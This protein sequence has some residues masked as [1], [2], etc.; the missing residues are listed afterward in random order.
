[1]NDIGYSGQYLDNKEFRIKVRTGADIHN[2]TG[3]A[4]CGEMLLVTGSN[5]GLYIATETSTK[6]SHS[7]YLV[8]SL[9][10][11]VQSLG[12]VIS[13]VESIV[14]S[15]S[16]QVRSPGF[17]IIGDSLWISETGGSSSYLVGK[18]MT[19]GQTIPQ[20]QSPVKLIDSGVLAVAEGNANVSVLMDDN[21]V[22]GIGHNSHGQFG[23]TWSGESILTKFISS[24]SAAKIFAG[25]NTFFYTDSSGKLFAMGWNN[26]GQL[27][28]GTIIDKNSATVI[29]DSGVEKV[30]SSKEHSLFLKS[31][32]TL[33]GVGNPSYVSG[34]FGQHFLS[35]E[36]V[37]VGVSDIAAGVNHSL[38]AKSDGSLWGMGFNSYGQ[39]G[40]AK[41]GVHQILASGVEKVSA[42]SYY[43][44][45]IKDDGSLWAMGDNNNGQLGNGDKLRQTSPV[46]VIDSG[47]REVQASTGSSYYIAVNG[48]LFGSGLVLGSEHN[49][50]QNIQV[51]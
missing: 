14:S 29:V 35:P 42:G 27:G 17:F 47:V 26:N 20:T 41:N 50:F 46:K 51:Y 4:I 25:W 24:G 36:Q 33:Y 40:A 6:D 23:S 31:D 12:G 28:D 7:I 11:T 5:P 44:F 38:L 34:F 13:N 18:Q 2:A 49:V 37:A 15:N 8:Q 45:F 19:A 9:S 43:S 1:M 39:L 22:W 48:D 32:G 10:S 3:D 21:S 30:S 16:G